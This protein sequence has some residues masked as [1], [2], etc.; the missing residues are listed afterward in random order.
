LLAAVMWCGVGCIVAPTLCEG[1]PGV[2][3]IVDRAVVKARYSIGHGIVD[4][5]DV[6]HFWAIFLQK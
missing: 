5:F 4:A 1:H 6:D 2:P 3:L